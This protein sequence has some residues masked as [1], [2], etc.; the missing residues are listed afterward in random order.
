MSWTL[1]NQSE[2]RSYYFSWF[3]Q[4]SWWIR[5]GFLQSVKISFFEESVYLIL[6]FDRREKLDSICLL[7]I[8]FFVEWVNV[9]LWLHEI[10]NFDSILS[11]G[12]KETLLRISFFDRTVQIAI[13]CLRGSFVRVTVEKLINSSST[14]PAIANARIKNRKMVQGFVILNRK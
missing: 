14:Y 5:F 6:P 1:T 7:G 11:S 2:R 4:F 13:R 12:T 9:V 3:H 8:S 10:E